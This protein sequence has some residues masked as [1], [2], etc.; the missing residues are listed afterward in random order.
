MTHEATFLPSA[1]DVAEYAL[2]QSGPLRGLKLQMLVYYVQ[3][4]SMA[5]RGR[6]MFVERIQAWVHGPVVCELWQTHTDMGRS[7]MVTVGGRAEALDERDRAFVREVL[8]YYGRMSASQLRRL[9]HREGPWR[10]SR[11]DIPENQPSTNEITL[12]CLKE[13]YASRPWGA[14]RP[15]TDLSAFSQDRVQRSRQEIENGDVVDL[16]DLEHVLPDQASQV[17][18]APCRFP[19]V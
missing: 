3:A 12:E 9:A 16:D 6:P 11:G 4:W 2:Q 5:T 7:P 13:Y 14:G 1:I 10:E 8:H 18:S 17:R 15:A 19:K